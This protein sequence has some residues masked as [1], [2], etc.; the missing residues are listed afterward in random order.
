MV[1]LI[2]IIVKYKMLLWQQNKHDLFIENSRL[3]KGFAHGKKKK[4]C[5]DKFGSFMW[6]CQHMVLE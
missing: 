3:V 4:K 6:M 2:I 5:K 1:A